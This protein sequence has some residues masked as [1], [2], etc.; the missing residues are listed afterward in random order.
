M[1]PPFSMRW[2]C[3]NSKLEDFSITSGCCWSLAEN[4]MKL[5]V[6]DV[7]MSQWKIVQQVLTFYVF[8]SWLFVKLFAEIKLKML[9]VPKHYALL[10]QKSLNIAETTAENEK[11]KEQ[12]LCAKSSARTAAFLSRFVH[13]DLCELIW[14]NTEYEH[15]TFAT[16]L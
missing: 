4:Q 5:S 1:G 9:K 2:T 3:R 10:Q 13:M 7:H 11:Q 6:K 14:I 12:T 8:D 15:S 16:F